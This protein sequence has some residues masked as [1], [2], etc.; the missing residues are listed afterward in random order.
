MPVCRRKYLLRGA[1]LNH[2]SVAGAVP[3]MALKWP[4]SNGV[5]ADMITPNH[6]DLGDGRG[7][8]V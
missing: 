6:P 7:H 5:L 1:R 2:T 8:C 4:F 3:E